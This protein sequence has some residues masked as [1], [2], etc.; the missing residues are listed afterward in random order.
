MGRKKK[1]DHVSQE[2]E[3]TELSLGHLSK[4]SLRILSY[5]EEIMQ[6]EKDLKASLDALT[7]SVAALAAA[8]A[9]A[10]K[11]EDLTSDV[12]TVDGLKTQVD[13]LTTGLTPPPA[14]QP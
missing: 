1:Q 12:A 2:L 9:A 4:L 5:V 11:P 13:T 14:T 6:T 8:V 10:P 3:E 7:A